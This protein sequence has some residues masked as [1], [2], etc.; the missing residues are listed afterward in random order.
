[1]S[2]MPNQ[3]ASRDDRSQIAG[4][5]HS[6]ERKRQIVRPR[7]GR[8]PI[9]GQLDQSQHRRRRLQ[10]ADSLH[11]LGRHAFGIDTPRLAPVFLA[12]TENL[13]HAEFRGEHLAYELL[14]LG[15]EQAG[16]GT[17]LFEE[18]ERT[19]AISDLITAIGL[20]RPERRCGPTKI[21]KTDRIPKPPVGSDTRIRKRMP[22]SDHRAS[23]R[24]RF[25]AGNESR[26]CR[27]SPPNSYRKVPTD[28]TDPRGIPATI[29]ENFPAPACTIENLSVPLRLRNYSEPEDS[30]SKGRQS[31]T[32]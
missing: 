18:S 1:M 10:R 11:L 16:G 12:A 9:A 23:H 20:S 14:P 32:Y 21:D 25:P 3:S 24:K 5:L 19:K 6:V 22:L 2:R 7:A 29:P 27:I 13:A 15:H 17:L 4:V 28:T 31:I 8:Q 30:F 26:A